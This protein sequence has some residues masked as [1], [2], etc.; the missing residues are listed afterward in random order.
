[1]QL[2]PAE[3]RSSGAA[4]GGAHLPRAGRASA[5]Q[6]RARPAAV[7][8]GQGSLPSF[9]LLDRLRRGGARPRTR[10]GVAGPPQGACSLP[11]PLQPKCPPP[12]GTAPLHPLPDPAHR[13]P[14]LRASLTPHWPPRPSPSP[15]APLL[16]L[17]PGRPHLRG[18][19]GSVGQSRG[20]RCPAGPAGPAALS[21]LC[22]CRHREGAAPPDPAASPGSLSP[23]APAL[24]SRAPSAPQR[25]RGS[26]GCLSRPSAHPGAAVE[27]AAVPQGPVPAVPSARDGSGSELC[28]A[29]RS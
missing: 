27:A 21:G 1:M 26:S 15:A 16:L 22:W 17:R 13:L 10:C 25:G 24:P 4:A 3:P 19:G 12:P 5:G 23:G 11:H 14:A 7:S 18:G 2:L 8:H 20:C 6:G 29:A 9:L 28:P